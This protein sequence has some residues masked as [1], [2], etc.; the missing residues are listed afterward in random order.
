[1]RR[2]LDDNRR[3]R[4]PGRSN[5]R[6]RLVLRSALCRIVRGS[7][8][9]GTAGAVSSAAAR[10]NSSRTEAGGAHLT[11]FLHRSD[12]RRKH[13]GADG[14]THAAEREYSRLDERPV[15]RKPGLP[16][17][18]LPA[19]PHRA[20]PHAGKPNRKPEVPRQARRVSIESIGRDAARRV[21]T[22]DHY[23]AFAFM[24]LM[25]S[26]NTFS[27]PSA[28]TFSCTLRMAPFGSIT[29]LVRSQNF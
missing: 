7:P 23:A 19:P 12:F 11:A 3:Q 25:S 15:C 13:S 14:G 1:M 24:L 6:R 18:S 16:R 28:L 2:W 5:H 10:G 4:R 8:A 22:A 9:G 29:K 27:C 21:S 17:S 26:S 20:R